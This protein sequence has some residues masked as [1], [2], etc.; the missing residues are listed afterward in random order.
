MIRIESRKLSSDDCDIL[1]K[2]TR[3]ARRG[4]PA[5]SS[6]SVE[7][8]ARDIEEISMSTS[9]QVLIA[10]D[11]QEA[12]V[13]W[14]Q[15]YTGFPLM[16]FINGLYPVVDE[17]DDSERI[18]LALIEASKKD[19]IESGQS[20]LEIELVFLSDEHRAHSQKYIEWYRKCGFQFA[21]EEMHMKSDLR[22][23]E[24]PQLDLP[25]GYVIRKF[26]EVSYE[27]L[28]SSGRRTLEDSKEG[29][30]LSM[31]HAEQDITLKYFFDKS[32]PYIED[33]SVI[34]EQGGEVTGFVITRFN[35]DDEPEIGPVGL[36]P[37]ARGKGLASYLL[38]RVLKSLKEKGST[39]VYLDTTI[40]NL[41]AQKLYRKYGFNDVYYKQFYYWSP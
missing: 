22:A 5:E 39:S 26:S 33:A 35:D 40:T 15:Y 29:L 37:E 18:A 32:K 19:I 12:I 4:T 30:F 21:A 3:A 16:T 7:E 23:I 20:R 34:L 27:N 41:P 28:E 13:G 24:L 9:F 31:S 36:V 14:M 17:R 10:I 25:N 38:V 11:D 2:I 6:K 8:I 1:A